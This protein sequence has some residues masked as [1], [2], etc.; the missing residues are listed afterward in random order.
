MV[1]TDPPYNVRVRGHVG[2]RGKV[3][4]GEFAFASGEM[5][6]ADY[7]SFLLASLKPMVEACRGGALVY[8]FIDWRHIQVL[9]E[10]GN[11]LGFELVNICAWNKPSPGQGSFYR[12]ANEFV[13]VFQKA[14]GPLTNNISLGRHGRSRTNVWTFGV[15]NKFK[16]SDD[17]LSGHPT[18]KPVALISEA[19]KDASARRSIIIDGFLGSGTTILAAEKVGRIGYGV[20]FEP[21]YC[22]LAIERWQNF[23]GKDA[24]LAETGQPF[25]EVKATGRPVSPVPS[26]TKDQPTTVMEGRTRGGDDG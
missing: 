21:R 14:G 7:R 15:P 9:C 16:S 25:E 6:N 22:D 12:S 2:G 23:T 18:P 19:I 1:I 20:E 10:V 26:P 17:P 3:R 4:H 5:S 13:A 24:V 8:V 11:T